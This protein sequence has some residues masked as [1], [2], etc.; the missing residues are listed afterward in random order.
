MINLDIQ[1][2]NILE[3]YKE[4]ENSLNNIKSSEPEKLIKL[5]REYAELK[6]IVDKILEY[7]KEQNEI[8]DLNELTKDNDQ[9]ISKIAENELLEKKKK[10]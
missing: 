9:E 6:P 7:K 3:K 5:N 4:I 2:T 1:L 8:T 10:Y